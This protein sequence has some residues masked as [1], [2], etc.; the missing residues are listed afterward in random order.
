RGGSSAELEG[1][2]GFSLRSEIRGNLTGLS[3]GEQLVIESLVRDDVLNLQFSN[4]VTQGQRQIVEYR[5][6][7][8]DGRP[9]P[10]WLERVGGDL[11]LGERPA[12]VET[13][14]LRVEGRFNDGTSVVQEVSIHAITGEIQPLRQSGGHAPALFRDQFRASPML[15]PSEL[16]GLGATIPR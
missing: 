2:T 10:G 5:V 3:G 15:T 11:M 6:T 8:I 13:I 4:T 16:E 14:E 1:L 7:Q 12:D 9:V